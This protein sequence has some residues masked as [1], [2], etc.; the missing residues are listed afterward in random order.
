[1]SSLPNV[2]KASQYSDSRVRNANLSE[3]V[4]SQRHSE[5]TQLSAVLQEAGHSQEAILQQALEQAKSIMENARSFTMNQ[6]R[7]SA[8][9]MNEEA[10]RM[11]TAG[12]QE[13]FSKGNAEGLEQGRAQGYEAGYAQGLQDGHEAGLQNLQEQILQ[14]RDE[15]TRLLEEMEQTKDKII[16]EFRSGIE[17]LSMQIARKVLHQ[18]IRN[19]EV[20]SEVVSA[21]LEEYRDQ[22]WACINL[23]PTTAELLQSDAELMERLQAVSKNLRIVPCDSM[24]D[25]DCQIDLPERQLDA[26]VDSQL[27]EISYE[28]H[29]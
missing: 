4:S 22:E 13:G 25:S 10:A 16:E 21:V 19:P 15:I 6:L 14:N 23:S 7:E 1:M 26:G 2:I 8:A 11:K 5:E 17:E 3:L 12:Y 18:E 29:F 9:Q 20:F 24:S 28:L 27:A